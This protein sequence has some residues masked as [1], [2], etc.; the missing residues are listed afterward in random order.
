MSIIWVIVFAVIA[1][2]GV[3]VAMMLYNSKPS[4]LSLEEYAKW[5]ILL[6]ACL[7]LLG[8]ILLGWNDGAEPVVIEAEPGYQEIHLLMEMD[9][10]EREFCILQND[11]LLQYCYL[12]K[13]GKLTVGEAELEMTN[14]IFE[15]DGYSYMTINYELQTIRSEWAF[16]RGTKKV[17]M[18]TVGYEFHIP[19]GSI[20]IV[21]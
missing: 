3:L 6:L 13:D 5:T 10:S 9:N 19:E 20:F 11:D 1:G 18:V 8:I 12:D 15:D 21:N 14:I 16:F 2:V 17:G 4:R 7:M